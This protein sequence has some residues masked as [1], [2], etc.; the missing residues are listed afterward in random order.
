MQ[1][2]DVYVKR[3]SFGNT[4]TEY[5]LNVSD[6]LPIIQIVLETY[7]RNLKFKRRQRI[8]EDHLTFLDAKC[9]TKES[10]VT[11]FLSLSKLTEVDA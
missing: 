1:E 2:N 4:W 11:K 5:G 7:R 10:Q 3:P 9:V 8:F 6:F